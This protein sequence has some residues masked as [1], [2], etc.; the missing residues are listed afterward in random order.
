MNRSSLESSM[1]KLKFKY[2][3][4]MQQWYFGGNP[5]NPVL[6]IPMALSIQERK[7]H[8][9]C[10]DYKV[11]GGYIKSTNASQSGDT[12]MSNYHGVS[13]QFNT[14]HDNWTTRTAIKR[15]RDYWLRMH[16][17][18]FQNNPALKPKW[19]DYKPMM[20]RYQ[21]DDATD[22]NTEYVNLKPCDAR[23]NTL[24]Y[25]AAGINFSEY[26]TE[27]SRPQNYA[28]S[29]PLVSPDKDEF[30]C[31]IIG[32]SVGSPTGYT[33]VGLIDSWLNSRPK[34]TVGDADEV[35]LT[36]DTDI[37]NDPLNMLFNDGDA[38]DE[39][40]ENFLNIVNGDGDLEGDMFSPYDP[41]QVIN[42][43]QEQAHAV[44]SSADPI[45]YF[46][47]FNAL[48]GLIELDI[49]NLDANDDLEIILEVEPRGTKI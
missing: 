19:H 2:T 47:G 38:D 39:I 16:K 44:T 49:T 34:L 22:F 37:I 42:A 14:V 25:Q 7:L 40:I 35:D 5:Y 45:A 6:N 41:D 17:E 13:V 10:M 30:Q 15:G 8:R 32:G 18:I 20:F 23:G 33:S 28:G 48:C 1:V 46:S 24:P 4:A 11:L 31:H 36:E 3:A 27:D 12:Q 43:V 9:A 29:L 21:S 26:V